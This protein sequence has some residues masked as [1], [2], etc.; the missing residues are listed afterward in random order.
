MRDISKA[1]PLGFH[2]R[3]WGVKQIGTSKDNLRWGTDNAENGV[4]GEE[5]VAVTSA[6]CLSQRQW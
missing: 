6:V 1:V 2:G 4:L 5:A 3:L